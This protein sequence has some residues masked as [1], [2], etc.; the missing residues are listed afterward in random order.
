MSSIG[1]LCREIM[2][3]LWLVVIGIAIACWPIPTNAET[4]R[5]NDTLCQAV[6]PQRQ[7]DAPLP[8]LRF[9][10]G[11][12][13]SG[14]QQASL[15]LRADLDRLKVDRGDVV[16]MLHQ[17]RFDRLVVSF[18]YADGGVQRQ[19]VRSGDYGSHWRAGGQIAFEAPVRDSPLVAVTLRFDRLASENLLHIR[20][21][22]RDEAGTQ[23]AALAAAIGAALM[24]LLVAILYNLSLAMAVRRQFLAWHAG[25][26]ACMLLWGMIWS[27]LDLLLV[28]VMA[29]AFSA[30]ICTFLA[31]LAITLATVSV[32]T[33]LG[34]DVLPGWARIAT[35][36]LGGAVAVFGVP[37]ALVRSA[38]IDALAGV[39]SILVLADLLAVAACLAWAWRRG[40]REARDFSAAWALPM[41]TLALIQL[42][43]IDGAFWGAGSK[44]VIL[45]AAAW[46]TLWLSIAATRRFARLRVERDRARADE[47]RAS[48][49]ARRDPLTGLRNR[50][51]F[52][53]TIAP[54][55]DHE[56]SA[57]APVALLLID[58]DQ[59]KSVNDAHGHEA[60]D[61]VLVTIA[62][63]LQR[64]EGPM[65]VAARLGGEEFALMIAGI[66]GFALARFAESV[67][68]EIGACDHR[69][70]IGPRP[71]TASIGVTET[72]AQGDFQ[73]LYR[74]ADEA[75]YAGKQD[76][77][78]RVVFRRFSEVPLPEAR[79]IRAAQV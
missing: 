66:E 56:R 15:W 74:L 53:E 78:N 64:W 75:L 36:M 51:G 69:E 3:C 68:R 37:L 57:G 60:G 12:S 29:G 33:S 55:L 23:S 52:I 35:S 48:E 28:P 8:A 70:A 6:T 45:V 65:C 21:L 62:E 32:V 19:Q 71:V 46:Q 4:L 20:L 26:A 76:G 77:R 5:L 27:Q 50:R 42:V 24:L 54:L 34:R 47:A 31:C 38:A 1:D 61:K 72:H 44:L 17:S 10:C 43:D 49:L 63:R 30:Q 14:Y 59:F 9:S 41:A 22:T 16:L 18:S 2:I 40:S 67:C 73:Q 7:A 13:S 58:I 11:G 39:A 79:E 25:W